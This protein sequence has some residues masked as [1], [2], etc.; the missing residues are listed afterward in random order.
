[1]FSSSSLNAEKKNKTL[2]LKSFKNL[3][4]SKIFI[5]KNDK[6]DKLFIIKKKNNCVFEKRKNRDFKNELQL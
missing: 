2:T 5:I 4:S 1:M 3:A 6:F